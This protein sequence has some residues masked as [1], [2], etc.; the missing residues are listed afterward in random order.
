MPDSLP[1]AVYRYST[2][3]RDRRQAHLDGLAP[4]PLVVGGWRS[5]RPPTVT[6]GFQLDI[7]IGRS[8]VTQ[9]PRD[10]V[11]TGLGLNETADRHLGEIVRELDATW[12]LLAGRMAEAGQDAPVRWRQYAAMILG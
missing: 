5:E 4:A 12:R 8:V 9:A 6:S 3:Y 7:A 1:I 2:V 11:L 10:E